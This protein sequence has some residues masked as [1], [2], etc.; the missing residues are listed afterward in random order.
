MKIKEVC[1]KTG[2]TERTIRFYIEEKLI[3]PEINN[4][5]GR[6]YLEFTEHDIASLNDIAVLRKFGFSISQII[7][8]RTNPEI[9]PD[10]VRALK[11]ETENDLNN[12]RQAA[13]TLARAG[14]RAGSLH[15]LAG[16]LEAAAAQL[17]LPERDLEPHFGRFDGISPSQKDEEYTKFL[18]NTAK[19][20]RVKLT[21][22]S[23]ICGLAIAAAS[24]LI[25]LAATGNLSRPSEPEGEASLYIREFSEKEFSEYSD[26]F[27]AYLDGCTLKSA[28]INGITGDLTAVYEADGFTVTVRSCTLTDMENSMVQ[29][30]GMSP[31]VLYSDTIGDMAQITLLKE[32]GTP[33]EY[34]GAYIESSDM[35]EDELL[36]LC[37]KLET[38]IPQ[39]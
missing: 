30:L 22:A 31:D 29:S 39:P 27:K 13:E 20:R 36:K 23:V 33:G 8:M 14:A 38:Y 7:L 2:L 15:Q 19:R 10:A 34:F 26:R 9:I 35:P 18:K 17:P 21:L 28:G 11:S 24:V 32:T 16:D 6:N 1:I 37:K 12:R 4:I 5:R 3:S 25:T